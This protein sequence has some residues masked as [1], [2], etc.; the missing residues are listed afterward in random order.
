ML[1]A[2]EIFIGTKD[3]TCSTACLYCLPRLS[4]C[5]LCFWSFSDLLP[6]FG[7]SL[8]GD[9]LP[10]DLVDI[11]DIRLTLDGRGG[12]SGRGGDASGFLSSRFLI[13][14]LL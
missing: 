4:D 9:F 5:L 1:N 11:V 13:L 14:L 8:G 7:S 2:F 12:R 6:D 3:S 10:P